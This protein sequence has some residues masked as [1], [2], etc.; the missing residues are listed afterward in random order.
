MNS[1][2]TDCLG[3]MSKAIEIYNC[4]AALADQSCHNFV[5]KL[6]S[7]VRHVEP[8]FSMLPKKSIDSTRQTNGQKLQSGYI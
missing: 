2:M 7:S 3:F 5:K 1:F 6:V 4:G 8:S